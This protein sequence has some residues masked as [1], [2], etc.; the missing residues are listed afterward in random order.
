MEKQTRSGWDTFK[1]WFGIGALMFGTYCGANM[2]S[3]VYASAYIVTLGGGWAFLWLAI[4]CFAMSFFC[5][6]GLDFI[7]AYK[8]SNYNAYYLALYGVDKPNS[9]PVLKGIVTIFFDIYTILMGVVTVAATVALFAELFN[10]LLGV[11]VFLGSVIAVLLFTVLTIYGASFLRKFNTVMTISLILSLVAILIAV[12]VVRGDVLA[13]RIG[14]FSIGPDWGLTT[15]SAHMSMFISYCFTT[16]NWGSS[17]SNYADQI[18]TKKDAIGS[19]ITI[20]VLVTLLFVMTGAI[21]LPFMPE[22][23]EGTPILMICQQY[24]SPVL[25]IVYWIVVIF[26]V[27]S[28]APTFTFNVANR[29][30][31]VWKSERFR[32]GSSSLSSPWPSC[33]PAGSSPAWA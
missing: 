2:A 20:G 13:E 1:A 22:V 8:T 21:V 9:N 24:L 4:F 26:S 27:V 23:Y 30:S 18:H 33:W 17:L 25:T 10:S 31:I 7:R 11:P 5:A 29:W 14:N 15:V 3:G 19:G 12:I 16:S 32:R 28:T 6:I